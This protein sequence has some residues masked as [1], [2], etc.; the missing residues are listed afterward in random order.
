MTDINSTILNTQAINGN[1]VI[2]KP[3]IDQFHQEIERSRRD[4]G[5]SFYTETTDFVKNNQNK[6]FND[7]KL[8]KLVS[9]TINS[10]LTSASNL[11]N[12]KYVD[13]E[14]NKNTILRHNQTLK[15]YLKISLGNDVYD[16]AKFDRMH[17]TD[18]TV[19]R[20]PNEKD[21][22]YNIGKKFVKIKIL[23]ERYRIS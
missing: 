21:F 13:D 1:H 6:N 18:T 22:Y 3:Y 10:N 23:M 9:I 20:Y 19:I 17:I 14:V 15:N 7:K 11:S 8:T 12:E 5:K 2:T 16:L 4:I